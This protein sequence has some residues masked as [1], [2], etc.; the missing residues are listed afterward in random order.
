MDFFSL[1]LTYQEFQGINFQVSINTSTFFNQWHHIAITRKLYT[2]GLYINGSE[3]VSPQTRYMN[4]SIT[5][6]L[7]LSEDL[8]I[9][10]GGDKQ[11]PLLIFDELQIF[12]LFVAPADLM[13][14]CSQRDILSP[15]VMSVNATHMQLHVSESFYAPYTSVTYQLWYSFNDLV[16]PFDTTACLSA[17][18]CG[19]AINQYLNYSFWV[20][21][22]Y[23]F[24]SV[25]SPPFSVKGGSVVTTISTTS[26]SGT[27]TSGSTA[28]SLSTGITALASTSTSTLSTSLAA[29]STTSASTSPTSMSPTSTSTGCTS[30]CGNGPCAINNGECDYRVTCADPGGVV[31]CGPCPTGTY[32]NETLNFGSCLLHCGD[33]NC[34]KDYGENCVTCPNDCHD[35]ACGACGD[36]VC[37]ANETCET[38]YEDCKGNCSTVFS[39]CPSHCSDHGTCNEGYCTCVP[40]WTGPSCVSQNVRIEPIVNSSNPQL[41]IPQESCNFFISISA[42]SELDQNKGVLRTVPLRTAKFTTQNI[43]TENYTLYN[44]STTLENQAFVTVI[45]WIFTQSTQLT[46]AGKVRTYSPNTVKINAVI[47]NWPFYSLSNFLA[48]IIDANPIKSTDKDHTECVDSHEAINGNL[49]WIAVTA[50]DVTLYG[51]FDDAAL[52]DERSRTISY[53]LNPDNSVSAILP[54]FWSSAKMDPQYSVILKDPNVR[55]K[56]K[57]K[58]KRDFKIVY[59]VVGAGVGTI[60][61]VVVAFFAIRRI[62]FN[63]RV[64]KSF[65]EMKMQKTTTSDSLFS[66]LSL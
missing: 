34:S 47:Q 56:T 61:L 27:L 26:N 41:D 9:T 54:H 18:G 16:I 29:T 25:S 43:T 21:A 6:P 3:A 35:I 63:R 57:N 33:G 53:A 60:L 50:S 24:G 30:S 1:T 8:C 44:F 59:I 51:Q 17:L 11:P 49:K 66:R 23:P 32:R 46:F 42:L 10:Q 2:V 64:N 37:S 15:T 12:D 62:R 7:G 4:P 36:G 55:C 31:Q 40:P 45:A 39:D 22:Q 48:V 38:C 20:V 65:D 5:S 14:H 28:G 19:V 52:V 13:D 58:R